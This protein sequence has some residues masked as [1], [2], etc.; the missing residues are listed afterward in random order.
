MITFIVITSLF[1]FH[2]SAV[3]CVP[4]VRNI[5]NYNLKSRHRYLTR[6]LATSDSTAFPEYDR[7]KC[8]LRVQYCGG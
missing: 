7:K 2:F 6:S 3:K 4:I 8:T 1:A 5:C